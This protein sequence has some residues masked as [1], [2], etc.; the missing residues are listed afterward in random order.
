MKRKDSLSRKAMKLLCFLLGLVLAIMLGGTLAFRSYLEQIHYASPPPEDRNILETFSAISLGSSGSPRI[1][2]AG[3]DLINILLIGQD[4][5]EGETQARSDSMI[6]CT[7]NKKTRQMT[8]TS[9]LRDLYVP[10]PGHGSNRINAAYSCGGASLL[11]KT[12]GQNFDI[13]I[14]GCIEVDF[15]RFSEI[16]DHMGGVEIELRQDEADVINRQTGSTLTEG[17]Q[18]LDG[19]QALTYSRIR[20]LDIDGDFSRTNRQRKVIQ[21]L[22]DSVRF[23]SIT[24]L[25]PLMGKILPM[26]TTDMNRGQIFLYALEILPH[27][28]EM[29]IRSQNIPVEGTFTDKTIDGMSVLDANMAAQRQFLQKTLSDTNF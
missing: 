23:S 5:R 6:L 28:A 1:G 8:A 21:A 27:L 17:V 22:A 2:G 25:T 13:A 29:D 16:I 24:E 26:L 12:I 9:F 20:N 18:W 4:A 19:F 14:D 3:S 7:F 11:K 10:I 15:S